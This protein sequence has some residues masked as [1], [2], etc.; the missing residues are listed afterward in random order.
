VETE[1][2]EPS[3]PILQRS[4]A[5]LGTCVPIKIV[6]SIRFELMSSAYETDELPL[7]QLAIYFIA[8]V[9]PPL[10]LEPR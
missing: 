3:A 9:V 4:V 10:G 2:I 8:L 7:L 5:S 1:G 6:A